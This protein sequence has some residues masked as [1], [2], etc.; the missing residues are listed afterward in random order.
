MIASSPQ[1][2]NVSSNWSGGAAFPNG[3]QAVAIVNSAIAVNQA[4][5]LNQNITLGA[6][7]V[8]A[9][10]GAAAFNIATNGGTLTLDN[11]PGLAT[12]LQLPSS[13]GDTIS[14]PIAVNGNCSS[15]TLPPTRSLCPAT[16]PVRPAASRCAAM[17]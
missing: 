14:A 13:A 3:T 11:T 17:L 10:G 16:F 1:S 5:N 4:I 2:W 6:M 15:R 8:G 12:L 7:S 9:S